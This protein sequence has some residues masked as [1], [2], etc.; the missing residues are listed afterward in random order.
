MLY[1]D[2]YNMA[3]VKSLAELLLKVFVQTN[4]SDHFGFWSA[5]IRCFKR[6]K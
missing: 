6:N 1:L 4:F 3:V 2:P 5:V